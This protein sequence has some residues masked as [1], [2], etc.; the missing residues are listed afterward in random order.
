MKLK[1]EAEIEF[2]ES[3]FFDK[4]IPSE[5]QWFESVLKD[6]A[7]TNILLHSNEIGDEIGQTN[8]FT[9]KIID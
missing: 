6:K 9:Y 1:I 3:W 2:D 4:E 8:T 7:S 5:L